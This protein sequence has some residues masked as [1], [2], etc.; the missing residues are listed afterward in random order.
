MH[1]ASWSSCQYP[2]QGETETE[3]LL[4]GSPTFQTSR[5]NKEPNSAIFQTSVHKHFLSLSSVKHERNK[6]VDKRGNN[7][8]EHSS[9]KCQEPFAASVSSRFC[10]LDK[11]HK[12][13]WK[14]KNKTKKQNCGNKVKLVLVLLIQLQTCKI[15]PTATKQS[16]HRNPQKRQE[17]SE[18]TRKIIWSFWRGDDD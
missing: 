5:N 18:R 3:S 9:M 7:N 6:W 10:L 15:L 12:A 13:E 11:Q 14:Q 4:R 8:C 16:L 2:A 1:T 17:N